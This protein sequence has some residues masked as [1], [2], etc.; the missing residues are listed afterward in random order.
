[1]NTTSTRYHKAASGGLKKLPLAVSLA[2]AGAASGVAQAQDEGSDSSGYV[3]LEE[4]VVTAQRRVE[5]TMTVPIAVDSFSA[6]DILNRGA[7]DIG[8]IDDF[9]A[10]VDISSEQNTQTGITIRGVSSPS[11]STAQDPS[12]ATFYDSAY[13]PRAAAA[14]PLVDIQ[15]VEVLKGPQGTLFGRNASAGVINIIPNRPT[16]E[17]EGELRARVGNHD[18]V[19]L[20]GTVNVPITDT[21]AVRGSLFHNEREGIV[22]NEGTGKDLSEQE[23]DFARL[24]VAWD[25]SDS[26]RLTLAGDYEDR[27]SAPS[28]SIGVSP[29]AV[30]TDPFS[31]ETA[32][33]VID[34][35]ETRE[36]YGVSLQLEHDF[37]DQWSMFAITSYRDWDTTNLQDEDGT[38]APRRYFDSNNIEDS[39]IWYNEVRFNFVEGGWNVIV[40]GNYSEE[41]VYQNTTIGLLGDSY[42]QFVSNQ[43][44]ELGRGIECIPADIELDENSHIWDICDDDPD[45][46]YLALSNLASA[47]Q[48]SDLA[49]LPPS[50]TGDYFV[51]NMENTGEFTNWGVFADATYDLTD[52][53]RVAAGLRY[54]YDEKDY[55]WQT[56]QQDLDWPVAL[57]FLNFDPSQTGTPESEWYGKFE[58]ND[59]WSKTTGRLVVDWEFT[60]GVMTYLSYATGYKSGGWDGN[61]FSSVVS[62]PFDPEEMTSYEW[63]LKGDFF[64]ARL[65]VEAAVF[66]HELEGKQ[67]QK[68]TKSSPDDP[69]AA[70]TIV[71]SDEDTE[72]VEATV[73]WSVTDN[74]LFTALGTV[75]DVEKE[76][77]PYFDAAGDPR[78]GR[79]INED[80]NTEYTLSADWT[81]VI[82][83][84]YLLVHV[85]Y[86]FK[87]AD[88]DSEA[89]IFTT[90]RWYFKDRKELNARIAWTNNAESFEVGIWGD[91]LLD[92]ENAD[93][94]GG[95]VAQDLG[96]YKTGIQD[97]R[98]YGVDFRYM[99]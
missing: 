45:S 51:E 40:G 95:F 63:G 24:A 81:P 44:L 60:E 68:S 36:M 1:M 92:R 69:T 25:V 38:A 48:G 76:E 11:I 52:T 96:A 12:V 55:T 73:R 83:T 6:Q 2:I 82:P 33:D 30:S 23:Y 32:N 20:E 97:P 9:M 59:D 56:E 53:V 50:F 46:T 78:G 74:L 88:D 4:V 18:L 86:V 31:G 5:N 67:N 70:P 15:R 77:E 47:V 21:I 66:Y 94:P 79:P 41:E 19:R 26:T 91:N 27:D 89:T 42:M 85:D 14:L 7:T 17:F 80:T 87:E 57:P 90:G 49:V 37:N 93:N 39:D 28:Y 84:G 3:L 58:D 75:R 98:T 8:D 22:N 43:L 72:G 71:T 61:Q 13:M 16:E 64:D 54:S 10:G 62:G 65:Q 99:F 34:R 35:E 29:Y